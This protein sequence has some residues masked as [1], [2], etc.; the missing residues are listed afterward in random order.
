MGYEE[1]IIIEPENPGR[2]YI[3]IM[4]YRNNGNN[5]RNN[6][7]KGLGRIVKWC[8]VPLKEFN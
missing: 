3:V 2:V 6:E 7:E 8:P 1:V 5:D 4:V